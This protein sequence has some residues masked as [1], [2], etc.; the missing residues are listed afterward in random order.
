MAEAS[1]EVADDGNGSD[2]PSLRAV[3]VRRMVELRDFLTGLGLAD[4]ESGD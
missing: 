4:F 2:T 1:I 3:V